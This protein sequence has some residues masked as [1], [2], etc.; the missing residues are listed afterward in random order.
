M[1]AASKTVIIIG[2]PTASGK[3]GIA[4]EVARALGT[5]IISADSRQCFR[6]MNIGVARPSPEELALVPH[7]FIATHS[8]TEKVN[9]AV[10]EKYALEK[11]SLL[12]ERHDTVVMT[13]G[14]GLYLKAFAEGLDEIPE[15][16][17]P[18]HQQVID[19]YKANGLSWLQDQIR[20][21]DP[22]FL[23]QGE[24]QNPQRLMRAL[25]VVMSTGRSILSFQKKEE[26]TRPFRMVNIAL[27][28]ERQQLYQQINQRV[29]KMMEAGLLQEV[30][31]LLPL[32][33]LNALQTVGYQELFDFIDG[34]TDLQTAVDKIKQ[35]TRNYA[36]RQITWFAH[37]GKYTWLP[38]NAE[39]VLY[40]VQSTLFK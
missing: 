3:T 26:V 22:S 38:G 24:I 29:D 18:I 7:H 23:D 27:Q 1:Q 25:E 2:G 30:R 16:P 19:Q 31:S 34:K 40:Y 15:V 17:D 20:L 28:V 37:K 9:A 32:R 39:E 5:E 14:T 35:H 33:H 11:V 21:N 10:F 13:G 6:E 8:V 36:K 4:I 12:F